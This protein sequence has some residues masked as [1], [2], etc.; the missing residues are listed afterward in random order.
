MADGEGEISL[1][2]DI[3][4][5]MKSIRYIL[6]HEGVYPVKFFAPNGLISEMLTAAD[7]RGKNEEKMA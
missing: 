4:A 1:W 6:T 7:N 5:V 3:S 2:H